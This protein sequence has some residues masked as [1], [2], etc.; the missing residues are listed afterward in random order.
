MSIDV[1]DQI[2]SELRALRREALQMLFVE[3]LQA[4]GLE[5]QKKQAEGAAF[6]QV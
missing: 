2:H 6:Q 1:P 3:E 4:E 5:E